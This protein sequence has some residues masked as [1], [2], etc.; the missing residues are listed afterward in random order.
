MK[1]EQHVDVTQQGSQLLRT[2][3]VGPPRLEALR[4]EN[5]GLRE[6]PVH[7]LP[8]GASGRTFSRRR[9]HVAR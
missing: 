7:V 8:V 9:Q 6:Q 2:L 1:I 5:L 3:P 4:C